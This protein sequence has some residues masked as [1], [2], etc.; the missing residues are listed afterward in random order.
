MI[1]L[2]NISKIYHKKKDSFT[3]LDNISLEFNNSGF[4]SILGPSG[5]GKTTLL[6]IIGGIDNEYEGEFIIDNVNTSKFKECNWDSYRNNYSSFIFQN[7]NLIEHINVYQNV[8]LALSL[9]NKNSNKKE[10]LDVLNKVGLSKVIYKMPKELSGGQKQRVAIARALVNNPKILLCDEPTGALDSKSSEGVME[11]LKE[12]ARDRLVIMVTHNNDL[13]ARYSNRIIKLND[14]KITYDSNS[15]VVDDNRKLMLNKTKMSF[16]KS[17]MLSF[18]NIKSKLF[19][20]LLT[21]IALSMG[22]TGIALILSISNGLK[23]QIDLYE[24]DTISFFPIVIK[25]D[26]LDNTNKYDNKIDLD[27]LNYINKLNDNNKIEYKRL[28]N[29]N[30]LYKDKEVKLLNN[31]NLIELPSIKS[32]YNVIRGRMPKKYDEIVLINNSKINIGTTIKLVNNNEFYKNIEGIYI[33]NEINDE[34]YNNINNIDLKV[35]GIINDEINNYDD[36]ILNIGYTS[37]LLNYYIS[38]NKSSNI[39][40]SQLN[41]D[42]I[43][44]LGNSTNS[45]GITRDIALRM[46]GYD[47][48]PY[49]I[50]IY[51]SSYKEKKNIIN[52]LNKNNGIKY[53]DFSKRVSD[54]S[55]NMMDI[56]TL[57]LV[58]FSFISIVITSILVFIITYVQVLER[59]KEI[60]ILRSIGARKKDVIRIFNSENFI[61]GLLSSIS[62]FIF[63]NIII[64]VSNK[65][66]YSLLDIPNLIIFDYNLFIML[67]IFNIFIAVISGYLPARKASKYNIVKMIN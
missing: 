28:I 27:G 17:L 32:N 14:G 16:R 62:S 3:A 39:V 30:L 1:I 29:F 44:F 56:I 22:I 61:L 23:R 42:N 40:K 66:I 49:Q 53:D 20:N 67:V 5:S 51:P 35:V 12:I 57:V 46:L 24:K 47:N 41:K 21:I 54:L 19:R 6:N 34:L 36:D 4:V 9:Q 13:A 64:V 26:Y 15:K 63:V 10:V 18:N 52:Y 2:K 43:V 58:L 7:Y 33:N 8:M 37:D 65:I 60:G 48:I 11:L 31:T 55:R 38:I 50:S 45:Y 25:N 59:R